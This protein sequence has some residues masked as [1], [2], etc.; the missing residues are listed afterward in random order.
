[1][2]ALAAASAA[3]AEEAVVDTI[4]GILKF[5]AIKEDAKLELRELLE[6]ARGR[7]ALVVDDLLVGLLSQIIPDGKEFYPSAVVQSVTNLRTEE[8]LFSVDGQRESP[9]NIIFLTRPHLPN[10]KLIASQIKYFSR[11]ARSQFK[12]CFVPTQSLV[13]MH[14]IEEHID[15]ADLWPRVSFMEYKIGFIPFDTDL[16]SMDMDTV[17]KQVRVYRCCIECPY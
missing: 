6:S 9:E 11:S 13:C 14:L 17:F 8:T 10:M 7:K 4:D 16:L 12:V 1:M 5:S 15:N 2:A 3:A